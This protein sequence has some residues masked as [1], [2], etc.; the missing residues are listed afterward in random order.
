MGGDFNLMIDLRQL[1]A[2]ANYNPIEAHLYAGKDGMGSQWLLVPEFFEPDLTPGATVPNPLNSPVKFA[3]SYV[4]NHTWV[5]GD[6]GTVALAL[7][8][9][10][11]SFALNIRSAVISMEL[12]AG[13]ATAKN[14]VIA[15]VLDTEELI[16][17]VRDVLG[18]FISC[19]G[20]AVDGILNQ[21]R[22]GSDIMKDGTQDPNA[23]CNGISIGLGFDASVVTLN[24]VGDVASPPDDPCDGGGGSGG[25]N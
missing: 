24:G 17:Q 12:D 7:N 10:G 25:G 21:L 1:G 11:Q 4:N 6:K 2:S 9:G 16:S 3:N 22:Q 8:I 15:G 19:D 20:S 14:G 13:R 18:P 23:E 5:S